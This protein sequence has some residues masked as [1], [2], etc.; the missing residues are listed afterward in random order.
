MKI[1]IAPIDRKIFTF[2]YNA[3]RLVCFASDL[4]PF[5]DGFWW[6]QR[7][8]NDAC[9]EG[10]CI[11]DVVYVLTSTDSDDDITAWH[12]TPLSDK[13]AVQY[14]TIFND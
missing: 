13:E 6:L 10:I 14:V 1:N 9:D 5:K 11:D 12:F 4:G 2:D 7:L 3:N 8:C